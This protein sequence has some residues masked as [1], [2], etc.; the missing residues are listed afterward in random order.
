M[1]RGK[2][3]F[4]FDETGLEVPMPLITDPP[5]K[6]KT[7]YRLCLQR[8]YP[9]FNEELFDDI[10]EE[11][12]SKKPLIVEM[13]NNMAKEAS[14]EVGEKNR[15]RAAAYR[16]AANTIKTVNAPII[17]AKQAS[18]IKGIGK[19]IAGK[20]ED[21]VV[22]SKT[23]YTKSGQQKSALKE[24]WGAGPKVIEEWT[25]KGI[26]S[27][28]DLRKAVSEGTITLDEK[29]II[30]LAHYEDFLEKIPRKEVGLF[31][32]FIDLKVKELDPEAEVY[33]VG[34]FARGALE[35]SDVDVLVISS[36]I[37][38][39]ED[40]QNLIKIFNKKSPN[41]PPTKGVRGGTPE[42]S[43][44]NLP[45]GL[46]SGPCFSN[47]IPNH[48]HHHKKSIGKREIKF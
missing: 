26:S 16:K 41:S 28:E 18:Y 39:S 46:D 43:Y 23:H 32:D 2:K 44:S 47:R 6:L 7:Y 22:S 42:V 19:G 24:V 4:Y 36:K 37:K 8:T 35:S 12:Y 38:S 20:I 13:L 48:Q 25:L 21:L 14:S 11:Y 30:G 5:S 34:S 9:N 10:Y 15:F 31:G 33:N 3:G 40:I 45:P 17:N 29:Q 1:G 27:I